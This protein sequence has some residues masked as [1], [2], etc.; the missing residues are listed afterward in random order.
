MH[1]TGNEKVEKATKEFQNRKPD[2][3]LWKPGIVYRFPEEMTARLQVT[4]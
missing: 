2:Q 1:Q 4:I 3:K